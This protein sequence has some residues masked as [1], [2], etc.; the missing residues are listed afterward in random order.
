MALATAA[1]IT[2]IV[3]GLGSAGMSIAQAGKAKRQAAAAADQRKKY[4]EAARKKAEVNFYEA[5][6]VPTSAYNEQFR[7]NQAGLTQGIQA[8]QEGDA[9]NIS[10]GIGSL[11]AANTQANEATRIGMEQALYDNAKMKADA[12]EKINQDLK[13]MDVGAAADAMAM[14]RDAEKERGMAIQSAIQGV[15]TA[16]GSAA[17][18]V[19]LFGSSKADK[20]ASA[21]QDLLA[22]TD[23][24]ESLATQYGITGGEM[25]DKV[26]GLGLTKQDIR[27]LRKQDDIVSGFKNLL[28]QD[29]FKNLNLDLGSVT[30]LASLRKLIYGT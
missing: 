25:I 10:A 2:G 9:R 17:D 6:N 13:Q 20:A 19:P 11:A 16:M 27:G 30:D 4:M 26:K 18:L 8:L 12:K 24:I 22:G 15:G 1:A 5:L 23:S 29:R 21:G 7:Q 3:T 28:G 14:Q